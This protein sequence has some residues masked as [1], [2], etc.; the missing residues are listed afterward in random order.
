LRSPRTLALIPVLMLLS[1]LG[2]AAPTQASPMT[3]PAPLDVRLGGECFGPDFICV[4]G[5]IVA[6][7]N[8][9]DLV[10]LGVQSTL[11][12]CR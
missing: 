1:L 10:Q 4:A 9:D 12:T 8:A 6:S 3:G 7:G 11:R 5:D 2:A